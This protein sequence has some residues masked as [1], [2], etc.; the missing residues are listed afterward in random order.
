MK[1][2]YIGIYDVNVEMYCMLKIM[3]ITDHLYITDIIQKYVL[4]NIL[5]MIIFNNGKR[6]DE[7][8]RHSIN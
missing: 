2:K 3:F 8:F 6:Y 7:S 4:K 5:Q 1:F